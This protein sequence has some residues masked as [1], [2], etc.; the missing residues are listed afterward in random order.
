MQTSFK[1]TNALSRSAPVFTY[2]NSGPR[3]I[4]V[5][6]SLHRDM[7]NDYKPDNS[8]NADV[9]DELINYLQSAALPLYN[10]YSD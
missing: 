5:T 7:M 8:S 9:V 3:T 1:E 4:Q 2:S 6:L 10:T